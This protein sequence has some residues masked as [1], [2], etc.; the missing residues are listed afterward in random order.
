MNKVQ[1]KN[2]QKMD[3]NEMCCRCL[4][5]LKKC[6]EDFDILEWHVI[7]MQTFKH[8]SSRLSFGKVTLSYLL[9]CLLSMHNPWFVVSLVLFLNIPQISLLIILP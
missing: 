4:I 9:T 7:C 6:I 2:K 8:K 3:C 1:E 5:S